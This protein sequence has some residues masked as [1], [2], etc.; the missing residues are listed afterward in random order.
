MWV[1]KFQ[2]DNPLESLPRPLLIGYEEQSSSA[3]R[4]RTERLAGRP[5]GCFQC[6]VEGEGRVIHQGRT[7]ALPPGTGFLMD[8][9]LPGVE[10]FYPE[11]GRAPWKFWYVEFEGGASF[12]LV[13]DIL[14]RRG[15]VHALPPDSGLGARV[16]AFRRHSWA[17]TPI[18]ASEGA[19]LVFDLLTDIVQGHEKQPGT[20]TGHGR[21]VEDARAYVQ[22]H[23]DAPLTVTRIAAEM[24]VSREHL[25][26]VFQARL[27]VSPLRY[28]LGE[29]IC[30]ACCLLDGATLSNK[31]IARRIGDNSPAH[32]ARVFKTFTG[33]TPKQFRQLR[34]KTAVLRALL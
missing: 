28:V 23:V 12:D 10:Y 2:I 18:A 30:L 7:L 17:T 22:G 24:G 26:R 5:Y 9:R 3:Y 29:K 1:T 32:F 13:R 21:L 11:G 33:V 8:T 4:H 14:D 31:E 27:G 6:S 20:E 34:D 15:P 19:K 25:C 16:M